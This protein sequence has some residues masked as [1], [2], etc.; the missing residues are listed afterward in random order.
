MELLKRLGNLIEKLD[1]NFHWA[2]A[3]GSYSIFLLKFMANY[4]NN[5]LINQKKP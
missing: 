2:Y 4:L 1:S 5:N 3:D